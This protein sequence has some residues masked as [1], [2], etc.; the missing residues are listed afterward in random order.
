MELFEDIKQFKNIHENETAILIGSGPSLPK[1]KGFFLKAKEK[2]F[3]FFG[4]NDSI[5]EKDLFQLDYFFLSDP[6]N[7]TRYGK[8]KFINAKVNKEKF[9]VSHNSIPRLTDEELKLANGKTFLTVRNCL[10]HDIDPDDIS[11]SSIF[12]TVQMIAYMG[13][14]KVYLAGCDC[15]KG[16]IFLEKGSN[17]TKLVEKWINMKKFLNKYFPNLKIYSLN[18]V[19]LKDIF[20]EKVIE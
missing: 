20:P 8:E 15:T 14:K 13:I 2:N 11:C 4:N 18:P 12:I 19:N 5:F 16:N 3:L 17:Y 1:N 9:F 10:F 6:R 7:L